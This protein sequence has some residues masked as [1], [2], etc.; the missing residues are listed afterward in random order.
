MKG[1]IKKILIGILTAE[2]RILVGRL[3]PK[4]VMVTG[5]IGKTSSKD[6]V[7]TALSTV[8]TA[9]KSEK[10][11]NTEIG[12]PLTIL[13][14]KN[15]WGNPVAWLHGIGLGFFRALFTRDYPQ[16]LVLEVGADH[17]GDLSELTQWLTP[18]MVVVTRFPKVAPHVEYYHSPQALIE[19]ESAPAYALKQEGV[20]ILNDDDE[21]VTALKEKTRAGKI[22]T[23]GTT[24]RAEIIGG[25]DDITYR[26]VDAIDA[27][28]VPT[29]MSFKLK[30]GTEETS[31][32][33]TDVLG[34]QQ[35][36]PVLAGVASGLALGGNLQDISKRFA[37]HKAPLGRMHIV[38][39]LKG[40]T[41]IDD[42]YN[43][44]PTALE[45]ALLTLSR[46]K[47][48]RRIGILGD[49]NELGQYSEEAHT[50]A[51]KW[52]SEHCDLL[53]T[54]GIKARGIAEGALDN[55]MLDEN[56]FQ[57]EEAREAGKF[58]EGKLQEG[59]IVLVKGSQGGIRLERAVEEIMAHPEDKEKLLVRQGGEWERR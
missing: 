10:S 29:G 24:P 3:K 57:F 41:I 23:F 30:Y 54:V 9:R 55:G 7:H 36:Y 32:T 59:D 43:S 42:S 20:L 35:M 14:L 15:P 18:D 28:E 40:S 49:M 6:A 52:A 46:V 50:E 27:R 11:F 34:V 21:S 47:A 58:L 37:S 39:G 38:E 19:E 53:L 45:Y 1:I 26:T 51:G 33:L 48:K 16:W 22:L 12:V 8:T 44:S 5:S 31:I 2:A 4:M 56:I 25:G 13:G 17:P